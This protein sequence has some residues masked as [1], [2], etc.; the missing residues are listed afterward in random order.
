M[1]YEQYPCGLKGMPSCE[2]A[3]RKQM[4]IKVPTTPKPSPG[5]E[6]FSIVQVGVLT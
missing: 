1:K 6:A 3:Q 4:P 2:V 5:F